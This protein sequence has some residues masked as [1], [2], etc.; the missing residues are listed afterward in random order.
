VLLGQP[1]DR[2]ELRVLEPG[3][4]AE[5]ARDL[6]ALE[7]GEADVEDDDVGAERARD[8]DRRNG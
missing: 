7:V 5:L 4:V 3:L 6:V 1:G 8:V 2:D